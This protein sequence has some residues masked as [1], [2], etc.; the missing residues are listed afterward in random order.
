[1]IASDPSSRSP[2]LRLLGP[3]LSDPAR[4]ELARLALESVPGENVDSTYLR[5]LR[6]AEGP[7]RLALV[8]SV[9]IRRIA[10]AA[11][12][13]GRLLRDAD[14][15]LADAAAASLGAIATPRAFGILKEHQTPITPAVLSARLDAAARQPTKAASEIGRAAC[16]ER[17]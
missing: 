6:R 8:Q 10:K 12:T 11:P 9:G 1:V 5:A 15:A 3:W 14:Q 2:A 4:Q 13:L 7:A 16:R 17:G